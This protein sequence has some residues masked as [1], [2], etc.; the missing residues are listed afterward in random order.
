MHKF[1]AAICLADSIA[2]KMQAIVFIY[3]FY[4]PT[5]TKNSKAT[6]WVFLGELFLAA[7]QTEIALTNGA[8]F[9]SHCRG[10]FEFKVARVLVH[11]LL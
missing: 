5:R 11:I 10:L 7:N 6:D 1:S 3:Y 4:K 9:V 2:S 8:D